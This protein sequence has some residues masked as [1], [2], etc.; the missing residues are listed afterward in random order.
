MTATITRSQYSYGPAGKTAGWDNHAWDGIAVD[1]PDVAALPRPRHQVLPFLKHSWFWL[2]VAGQAMVLAASYVAA[3][4]D[5]RVLAWLTVPGYIV[6]MAGAV[7]IVN[8]HIRWGDLPDF[9]RVL[10]WGLASGLVAFVIA[11]IIEGGIE[12]RVMPF[13]AEL[14]LAG[15]VE[16]T[17]KLLV[18]V[19]LLAFGGLAFKDPRAGLL[20]V[21]TSAAF[22]GVAEGL[23]Y[24]INASQWG[25]LSE[26][27][28]RPVSE[29]GHPYMTGI[30]APVI[31]LASWRAGRV[32]TKAGILSWVA[33]MA[34]HSVHD[35]VGGFGKQQQNITSFSG[36]DSQ[37]WATTAGGTALA[38]VWAVLM[39]L[40]TR[41]TARELTPPAALPDNPVH[42]RPQM[43][44]WGSTSTD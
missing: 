37:F 16:E 13:S 7:V 28:T 18:P 19:L 15:P 5:S 2:V 10:G 34:L 9:A 35:G 25:L 29:M 33:V 27:F 23:F 3:V 42:W 1:D 26:G 43:K 44:R 39:Y 41:H 30:A 32:V 20:L 36:L 38:A 4:N 8:R 21:M 40:L 17:S 24:S 22:F 6:F 12:P 11:R 14:W 31:W